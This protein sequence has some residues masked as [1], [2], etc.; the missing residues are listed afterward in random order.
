MGRLAAILLAILLPSAAWGAIAHDATSHHPSSSTSTNCGGSH[1]GGASGVTLALMW[2]G[3][4]A[5][6][7]VSAATYGGETMTLVGTS[8]SAS[9]GSDQKMHLYYKAD[10]LQ[11]T[12]TGSATVTSS[13]HNV[14]IIQTFS[15]TLTTAD[16]IVQFG[17]FD[18]GGVTC[19]VNANV[20]LVLE[21]TANWMVSASVWHGGDHDPMTSYTNCTSRVDSA[22]GTNTSSDDSYNQCDSTGDSGSLT[23]TIVSPTNDECAMVSVEIT[24]IEPPAA[25]RR[26]FITN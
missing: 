1:G 17:G 26:I 20:T 7:A 6:D 12:Q 18:N 21:D 16:A 23:H 13:N 22:T 8:G 11:G 14:C 3:L 15:G 9:L 24:D 2:V 5:D 4:D 25:D 19:S 10:P